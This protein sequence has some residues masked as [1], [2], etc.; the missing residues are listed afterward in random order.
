ML[1]HVTL[2]VYPADRGRAAEF[3]STLGFAEVEPPPD[4]ADR[5]SWYERD[6]TQIHLLRTEKPAVPERGHAAVV[7]P[8]FD[9]TLERLEESGF[10]GGA[11]SAPRQSGRAAIASS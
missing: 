3:W 8:E 10:D 2:E 1:H 4:L 9:R 7:V 6:G 5:Y 11:R